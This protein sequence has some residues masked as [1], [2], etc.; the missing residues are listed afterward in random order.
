MNKLESDNT[1]QN[2]RLNAQA[3][4]ISKQE[5]DMRDMRNKLAQVMEQLNCKQDN[6]EQMK[7]ET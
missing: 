5:D 7:H 4:R 3:G 2:V 1:V 6:D